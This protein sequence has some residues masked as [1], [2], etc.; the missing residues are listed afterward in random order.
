MLGKEKEALDALAQIERT[1]RTPK[2]LDPDEEK[3][4][5]SFAPLNERASGS[6]DGETFS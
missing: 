6:V 4:W 1:G 3:R 5:M 2:S